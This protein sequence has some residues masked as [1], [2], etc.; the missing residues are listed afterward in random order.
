VIRDLA[1]VGDNAKNTCFIDVLVIGAGIAG[2][3]VATR[4][5]R[6]DIRV[7][8][9]E[10]GGLTQ[11]GDR[12]P[13]NIV[14]QLGDIYAG[15]EHGRFRC[16][17]GT[18]TR[19]GGA[20]LPFQKADL[21]LNTAGWNIEWPITLSALSAYQREIELLF[22]LCDGQYE[23]PEILFD[24]D[25]KSAE[26]TARLAKW[27]T[28]RYRNV[29]NVFAADIRSEKGPVVWLNATATEF[30]FDPAGRLVGVLLRSH[31]AKTLLVNARETVIAAGAIES[32]RLLL[33]AD[34]Q[35]G[36]RIFAPHTVL[37]RYFYDHLSFPAAKLENVRKMELNRLIG[38][39]FDGS[40]MRNLRFEPTADLLAER[41]IP[42]GF[43]H[44]GFSNTKSSGFDA[45]RNVYRKLQRGGM[46]NMRDVVALSVAMPWL[47]R[48]VWWRLAEKRLLI[49]DGAELDVHTVIEQEPRAENRIGLSCQRVDE[50]GCPLATIDWRV[51]ENDAVNALALARAFV[52]AWNRGAFARLATIELNRDDDVKSVLVQGGGIFHPGGT[53]R[54]GKDVSRGV[55]DSELRTFKVPNLSVVSTATFPTGGGSN[56]TM[57]LMMAAL[58]TADRIVQRYGQAR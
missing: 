17:G 14:E 44:I 24:A 9:A 31:N 34:R 45:F 57:M 10:S 11:K 2:L 20:M 6:A 36:D 32:T 46:P 21:E 30:A 39:R 7:L 29:A 15:A 54:M 35:H 3:I 50:Y 51:H 23:A 40:T 8:V 42:A 27:P 26:F 1:Q 4:L 43:V 49:P 47:S 12:H 53:V 25:G 22:N 58:R 55:V 5:A 37:G 19:W 41:K 28:F 52:S 33:L 13:L 48:A 18:S 38:F 56:P 16:L